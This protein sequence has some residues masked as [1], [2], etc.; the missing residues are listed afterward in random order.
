MTATVYE[1]LTGVGSVWVAPVGESFPLI[2][3]APVGNWLELGFTI[4]GV[5]V[6]YEDSVNLIFVDQESGPV[7]AAREEEGMK[8]ST[9][10]AQWHLENI[11]EILGNT[12]TTTAPGAGVAGI[13]ELPN[14]RGSEVAEFAFLFRGNSP[15][16]AWNSQFEIPRA[17]ISESTETEFKKAENS[18]LPFEIAALVDLTASSDDEKF[19]KLVAQDVAALP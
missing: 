13:R 12:V 7:K 9:Q 6:A 4:D 19:G 15:Y 17:V 16:G 10:L 1:I 11:A 14:Y 3:D 2:D 18:V 5:K 8:V